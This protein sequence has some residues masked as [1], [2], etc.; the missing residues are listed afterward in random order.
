MLDLIQVAL[1]VPRVHIAYQI[2]LA[3]K[4]LFL[5]DDA[6]DLLPQAALDLIPVVQLDHL[7]HTL[8]AIPALKA[9]H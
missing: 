6:T 8:V 5:E 7:V 2:L 9:A 4:E 3:L 1:P